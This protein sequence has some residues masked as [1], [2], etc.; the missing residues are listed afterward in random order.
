MLSQGGV[1]VDVGGV[2]RFFELVDFEGFE[3][4]GYLRGGGY[5]LV[6]CVV[7]CYVLVLVGVDH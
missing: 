5:V 6:V 2:E 3:C 1:V 7:I 4:L